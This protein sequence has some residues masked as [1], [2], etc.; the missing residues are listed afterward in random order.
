MQAS[1]SDLTPIDTI[2]ETIAESITTYFAQASVQKL[3]Q[4][5]IDSGV[6][7]DYL[8]EDVSEEEIVDNFFKNKTVVLTG[9]L[10]HFTRSEFTKKLE[11]LGAKV[12]SSV[13][14]KTDYV[15]YGT[16][17]GSKLTK[18]ESLKIALLT[19]EEAIE[20]IQ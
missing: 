6:N 19:E 5:L 14:K 18:A 11:S 16:D 15:I 3:V 13:S 8:G 7:I 17:A 20:K 10:A 12:T 2:G 4:E 9:K 1:V